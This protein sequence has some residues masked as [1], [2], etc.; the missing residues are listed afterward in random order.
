M[1]AKISGDHPTFC[2]SLPLK[3][4]WICF[5]AEA[6]LQRVKHMLHLYKGSHNK[7]CMEDI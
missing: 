7:P 3:Q 5:W 1:L 6:E 4:V 2:P